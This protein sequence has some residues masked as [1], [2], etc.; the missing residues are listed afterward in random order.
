MGGGGGGRVG[1]SVINQKEVT[2]H[3][4][5]VKTSLKGPMNTIQYLQASE[6][7]FIQK[8]CQLCIHYLSFIHICKRY[9]QSSKTFFFL[10]YTYLSFKVREFLGH[11]VLLFIRCPKFGKD[12]IIISCISLFFSSI[13]GYPP[14]MGIFRKCVEMKLL[15]LPHVT[16]HTVIILIDTRFFFFY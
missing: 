5:R 6:N 16:R 12:C 13:I 9:T 2:L 3:K 10:P 14:Y 15:H 7:I 8:P 4:R 1:D 11:R